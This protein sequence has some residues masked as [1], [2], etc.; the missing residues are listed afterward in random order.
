T[1]HPL[2]WTAVDFDDAGWQSASLRADPGVLL[3]AARDDGVRFG[4][5]LA[6]RSIRAASDGKY[7]VDFGANTAGVV[8]LQ[9]HGQRGQKITLRHAEALDA[10][11]ELYV[12]NLRGAEQTDEFIL[13]DSGTITLEPRFTFHGFRFAEVSG[14][15]SLAESAIQSRV[16]TSASRLVGSFEC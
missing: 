5:D 11:G 6:P 8:R 12:E 4:E 16:L 7:I 10:D 15:T 3:V 1:R 2:A 14:V 13:A 9:T